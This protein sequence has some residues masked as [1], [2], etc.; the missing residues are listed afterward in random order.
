[1]FDHF[2]HI[3]SV[4]DRLIGPPDTGRLKHL[5]Q[6]PTTGWLLDGGGGTGRISQHLSALT[7]SVIV[8]DLS[9]RML[10][11]ALEKQLNSVCAPVERLPFG[12]SCFDRIVV[13]DAMHHFCDQQEAVRDLLRVLKTG[14]RLVIEEP[15]FNRKSVKILALLEKILLMRSHFNTPQDIRDMIESHGCSAAIE[16]DAG[17]RAWIVVDK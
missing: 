6:L 7:E 10:K 2:D 8:S 14:G 12:D 13:V 1:M 15:D 9:H 5:L 3:A 11:K 4:Y 16:N 17:Y